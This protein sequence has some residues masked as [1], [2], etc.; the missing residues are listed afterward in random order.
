MN[1]LDMSFGLL[2]M[3]LGAT[4][5]FFIVRGFSDNNRTRTKPNASPSI[6]TSQALLAV[7]IV[8]RLTNLLLRQPQAA[9]EMIEIFILF[10][11]SA[12]T[13]IMLAIRYWRC[14]Q[15]LQDR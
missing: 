15:R 1:L 5:L 13:L 6:I 10:I 11:A 4:A 12:G 8:A 14:Y 9:F 2:E 3:S 7:A